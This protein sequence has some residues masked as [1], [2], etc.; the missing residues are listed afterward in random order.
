HRDL[1]KLLL[2]SGVLVIADIIRPGTPLANELAA[3][4]YDRA[5]RERSVELMGNESG[6]DLFE[7]DR[8][9]LF[10]YPDEPFDQP[11]RVSDQLK[12]LDDAGFADVDVY[13]MRA[14]HAI[15]GGRKD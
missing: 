12:W 9:N 7:H 6:F 3:A 14:G 4:E 10:R 11:S 5:V 1:F 2:A 13:W 8:W 15:F